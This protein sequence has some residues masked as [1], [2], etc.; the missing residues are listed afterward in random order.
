MNIFRKQPI[1]SP[2]LFDVLAR[3]DPE[4]LA[5]IERRLLHDVRGQ[6]GARGVLFHG[7]VSR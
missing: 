3:E 6:R 4:R 5:V 2:D 1:K 7:R